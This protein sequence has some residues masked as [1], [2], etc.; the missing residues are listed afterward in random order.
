MDIKDR[1]ITERLGM[2]RRN[3]IKLAVGGAIGTALSPLPWKLTDDIAIWTQNLPWVPVPPVGEFT[4]ARS[5]C[6]LCPGG[7]GIKVRKVDERAVKIEG[8][9]DYPVNPGGICPLGMGGLQLLYNENIRFTGPMKR[10]GARGTEAFQAIS[11][12]EALDILAERISGLRDKGN[13]WALAAIDGNHGGSTMSVM[14]ERFLKTLG[15]PNY[16]RMQT[17]QDTCETS[18]YIL[19]GNRGIVGYDLENA[20]YILSFGSGLL[21]GWGAPGRVLNAWGLWKSGNLRDSVHIV[22]V[23]PRASNT[24]SRADSWFPVKPGTEAAL[25]LGIAHVIIKENLYNSDFVEKYSFGF[26]DFKAADGVDH[27]GFKTLVLEK[28]SPEKVSQITGMD[29]NEIQLLARHFASASAPLAICGR[30]KGALY[31][32]LYESMAV[33]ALN[34][35]VGGINRKGGIFINEPVSLAALPVLEPDV[36]AKTALDKGR[37]DKASSASFPFSQSLFNNLAE[38]V[39]KES[40]SPIDT[41]LVFS[42]NPAFTVP[43]AGDFKKTLE[44]IPFIVS[45]SPYRDE[46]AMLADL[47]LPDHTYLEKIDDITSPVGLQYTLYGVSAPV[48]KPLYETK[49]AGDTLIELAKKIGGAAGDAF[50]W[51][52]YEQVLKARAQG[53]NEI[54]AGLTSYDGSSLPWQS[55]GSAVSPSYS[56]FDQM[57]EEITENGLWYQQSDTSRDTEKPFKTQSGKFEFYSSLIASSFKGIDTEALGMKA[58]GDEICIPHFEDTT[59]DADD[60]FPL[61]MYPYELINLA[62]GWIPNP[63]YLNKT[64]LDDQ[65]KKDQSFVDINPDTAEQS[66]IRQGDSVFIES[67]RGKVQAL[68]NIFKGAMPGIVFMPLGFGHSAYDDFLRGKGVNPNEIIYGG[69]DPLSGQTIWWDT[70]VRIIKA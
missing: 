8:R 5:V 66:G 63:P 32:S 26:Y 43:E 46:T 11:W 52:D 61:R 19:T 50:P 68:V 28:Y 65:L 51:P 1:K 53:L 55:S 14:I 37:I 36:S 25:A 4:Y 59:S 2:N 56:D 64:L 12:D 34:A 18:A 47:I 9:T 44:K 10:V 70:P 13:I 41:M 57:W 45:F 22:Q 30:G 35:L 27:K 15:S 7:C 48:V 58:S 23:E 17:S 16:M 3:F 20:D 39:L 31:G 69:R 38:S 40:E 49:H 33:L 54:K 29:P 6:M 21:E 67:P 24:A 62:S 42:A 60:S